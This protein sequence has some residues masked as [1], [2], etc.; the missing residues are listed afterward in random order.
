MESD[1][2]G[3]PK[4][5]WDNFHSRRQL[6]ELELESLEE[7][8][9]IMDGFDS[10]IIGLD[11]RPDSFRAAYSMTA[12][13]HCCINE[14]GMTAEDSI[15]HLNFNVIG[16]LQDGDRSPIVIHDMPWL[17]SEALWSEENED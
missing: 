6:L 5:Q 10:C 3:Y 15:E 16:S 11:A 9:A 12:L 14:M 7:S 4:E 17:E 1:F 8:C 2:C 13:V